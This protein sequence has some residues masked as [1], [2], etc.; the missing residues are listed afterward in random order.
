MLTGTLSPTSG[1]AWIRGKNIHTN[2]PEIRRDLGVC[3]QHNALYP[4]LTVMQ[5]LTMFATFKGV[6]G[7]DVRAA[8]EKMIQEVGLTEKTHVVS[9]KLS[10][11]MKRKLCLAIALIGDSGI[12]ILDEPTS[13]M[14]PYSR[15]YAFGSL[16]LMLS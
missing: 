2:M 5:H 13:G 3:P 8:A 14:D 1:T 10:G 6:A 15:R 11:G 9:R 4:E 12:V 7:R 16:L